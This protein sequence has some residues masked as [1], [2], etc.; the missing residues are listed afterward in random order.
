[1]RQEQFVI[2]THVPSELVYDVDF[3]NLD[4]GD[5]DVQQAWKR[6]QD[7][8]PDIFWTPRNG[9]HWIAT[10]GAAHANLWKSSVR[11]CRLSCF[12]EW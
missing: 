11:C 8:A 12:W 5:G 2:P 6:I 7:S 9:G 4:L 10:R 1:M 3:Y